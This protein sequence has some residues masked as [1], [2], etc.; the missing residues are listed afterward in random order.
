MSGERWNA[1]VHRSV[2]GERTASGGETASGGRRVVVRGAAAWL[3]AGVRNSPTSRSDGTAAVIGSGPNGLAAAVVLARAGLQVTVYEAAEQYGGGMRTVPL[4]EPDTVH[5]ICSAGHPMAAA[6]P[7]FQA[8]DLP[9]HGVRLLTPALSYAHP[10]AGGR[11][12]LAWRD[13]AATADGLGADGPAWTRLMAPLMEHSRE[14]VAL[15]LSDLRR[16]PADP[17]LAL[18]LAPRMLRHGTAL[19]RLQFREE[20]AGALLSGVA[21]HAFGRLPSLTGG[22]IA[23]LLGHLAHTSGWPVPEGGSAAIGR[24]L[25]DD[26]TAHGGKIH[27]GVRID[28]L[29]E[30]R[31]ARIV[32]ADLGP[33]EFL[34]IAGAG[35]PP[36][37]A[38][39]LSAFRY[40]PA[41]AKTDFLLSERVPWT[42]PELAR[43][44]T[45]HLGGTRAEVFAQETRNA[46]GL[47]S[48]RPFVLVMDPVAADPGRGRPGHY[49]LWAYA[50]VPHGS[51]ADAS[52][53]IIAGIEEHA[54]GFRDTIVAQR[55]LSAPQLEQYNANYAG[56][57]IGAGAVTMRQS[58]LRPVPRRDPYR[59]PLPGVYLCSAS[60]PPG[61]GV[62]GMS[63]YLAARS[64]LRRESGISIPRLPAPQSA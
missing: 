13:L 49:P 38:A 24:A 20:P 50:H 11:A 26:L 48:D 60:T 44:G 41:A 52:A 23:L 4:F 39:A 25:A 31:P 37:Y 17:A 22:A 36:R 29:R 2:D 59:T 16:P 45:V 3:A 58:L 28:D 40:G 54:P 51:P 34:R 55:S 7:F 46:R 10:L 64:A 1:A 63:G 15:M 33:R 12:A 53:A 19:A 42:H 35:L 62:H 32:L 56:G 21:A 18:L 27:T 30:V 57:D 5:D 9:A 6:S 8:F 43:A 47:P 14:L 61:P